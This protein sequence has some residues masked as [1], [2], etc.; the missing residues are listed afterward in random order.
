[1]DLKQL[2]YFVRLYEDQHF[3]LAA[4]HLF[5]TQQ[6]LSKSIKRL[7]QEIGPLFV[8]EGIRIRSTP[9]GDTLY[10]E[11]QSILERFDAMQSRL[12]STHRLQENHL[13]IALALCAKD[14]KIGDLLRQFQSS[15]P[16]VYLELDEHPDME[17]EQLVLD[18]SVDVGFCIGEPENVNILHSKL[19]ARRPLCLMVNTSHSLARKSAICLPDDIPAAELCCADA[20]FKIYHLLQDLYRQ[21][22]LPCDFQTVSDPLLGYSLG[23][24]RKCIPISFLD[25]LETHA[26]KDL[27]PIPFAHN[28]PSWDI[29]LISRPDAQ[30]KLIVR[31]FLKFCDTFQKLL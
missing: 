14:Y 11:A 7:E 1:M 12:L 6:A 22:N 19:I 23:L 3:S 13:H 9:L 2:R 15:H 16:Q 31:Q 20:R 26:Y 4:S 8:R 17:V 24:N 18:S 10:E 21:A 5:I 28:V 30:P 29:Y 25:V 27:V